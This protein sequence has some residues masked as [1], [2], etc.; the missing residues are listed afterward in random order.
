MQEKDRLKSRIEN[1][2]VPP[3]LPFPELV[4]PFP[5]PSNDFRHRAPKLRSIIKIPENDAKTPIDG[6]AARANEYP[7]SHSQQKTPNA[8]L[9]LSPEA[10]NT[11]E[12]SPESHPSHTTSPQNPLSAFRFEL[13][14]QQSRFSIKL[15]KCS[16]FLL[17]NPANSL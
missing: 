9:F 17:K 8:K 15:Y 13:S 3:N 6:T 12:A 10:V 11:P 14:P 4:G 5:K 1:P 2:S 7:G 16:F